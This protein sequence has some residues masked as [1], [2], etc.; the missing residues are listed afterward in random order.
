MKE[1]YDNTRLLVKHIHL[2]IFGIMWKLENDRTSQW[3]KNYKNIF[4]VSEIVEREKAIIT[5]INSGYLD[6]QHDC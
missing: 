4:S 2:N 5:Q 3:V 6:K 1:S